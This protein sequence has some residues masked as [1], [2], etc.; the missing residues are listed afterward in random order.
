MPHIE[1]GI[2]KQLA[3]F[4]ATKALPG[5]DPLIVGTTKE[6]ECRKMQDQDP[7][8]PK[9]ATQ[10]RCDGLRILDAGMV[11][12]IDGRDRVQRVILEF[13]RHEF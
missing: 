9:C 4:G 11:K 5:V 13:R 3:N 10:P 1:S 6:F 8:R 2:R 7:T 12:H